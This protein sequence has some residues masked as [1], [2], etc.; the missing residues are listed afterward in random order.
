ASA[1]LE[2]LMDAHEEL[3][4][5][6]LGLLGPSLVGTRGAEPAH[7]AARALPGSERLPARPH[8]HG[9]PAAR[10]GAAGAAPVAS[11][12]PVAGQAERPGQRQPARG[13][14][15]GLDPLLMLVDG[16]GSS[17]V[18]A[19]DIVRIG[20]AGGLAGIDVPIPADIQSHHAD[21]E[22]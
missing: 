2:K 18:I 6:P 17:L 15:L 5:S 22:R 16:T 1:A 3:C 4:S 12:P 19:G 20:R 9:A 11:V 13:A 7:A 14:P 21:V 8:G 10:P